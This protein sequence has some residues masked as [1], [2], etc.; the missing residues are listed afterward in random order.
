MDFQTAC[1][2]LV[3]QTLPESDEPDSMLN[4]LRRGL[5]PVPGQA[6]ALLLALKVVQASLQG[7]PQID[8]KLAYALFLLTY[9]GRNLF[10]AGC[11]ARVVWPPL[12]DEDLERIAI[13][14]YKIFVDEPVL[15]E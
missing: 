1:Q 7:E 13:A 5:P 8:R 6:T 4:R 12:L 2:L 14:A 10:E 11:E 15:S 3:Q 9:E